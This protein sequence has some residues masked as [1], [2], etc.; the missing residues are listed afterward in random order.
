M[1]YS[2]VDPIITMFEPIKK[3]DHL[4]IAGKRPY[5]QTQL[6]DIGLKIISNTND[7]EHALIEC[8]GLLNINQTW[9]ALR[10]TSPPRENPY[11]KFVI[12]L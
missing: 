2:L 11:A 9:P 4:A 1:A 12:K 8:Y 6:V 7:F 3:L 10:L 5:T